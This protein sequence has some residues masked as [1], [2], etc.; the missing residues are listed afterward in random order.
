MFPTI[1]RWTKRKK[2]PNLIFDLVQLIAFCTYYSVQPCEKCVQASHPTTASTVPHTTSIDF[3]D[4]GLAMILNWPSR[5]FSHLFLF[6]IAKVHNRLRN[7]AESIAFFCGDKVCSPSEIMWC[8]I[9][10]IL[11]IWLCVGLSR[12][13]LKLPQ[14]RLTIILTQIKRFCFTQLMKHRFQV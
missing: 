13:K 14:T 3:C 2:R 9:L 12:R 11:R 6:T 4:T 7:H 10:V 8:K 1:N 5:T